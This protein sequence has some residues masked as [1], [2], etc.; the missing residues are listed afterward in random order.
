M[1]WDTNLYDNNHGFV[2][3]Y[4]E[5]LID[6]LDPKQ[7]E[8]ILDIG[9]GTGDLAALM[10]Q[11]GAKVVGLDNSVEMVETAR[12][13]Y[14]DIQF[15]NRS[16]SNFSYD[17]QF[18]A[19]F[20]NATLHWILEYEE[21]I[22]C[23]YEALRPQ[24][25]FVAEFGGK[26]NVSKITSALKFQLSKRGYSEIAEKPLWYFPSLSEY[27]S[28]LERNGFRVVFAAHFDR[29]TL[30]QGDDGIRN[31]IQ[32]FG[33]PYLQNIDKEAVEAIISDVET[34]IRPTNFRNG[35]WYADYVRLRLVA[36]K[37]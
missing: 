37:Q 30:L 5:S 29:E 36:I 15:D 25:R 16:A 23:I 9:C 4:G 8:Q 2:S 21:A 33:K 11:Q 6:L 24:G 1:K 20:S 34:Q 26:G 3:K 14:P 18:D 10:S 32:M 17:I 19:A 31:W 12:K 7:G 13:K 27:T 22:K 28:L 35:N